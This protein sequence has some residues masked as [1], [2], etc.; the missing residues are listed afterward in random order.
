MAIV[1]MES[2]FTW[3]LQ[4]GAVWWGRRCHEGQHWPRQDI[5][6]GPASQPCDKNLKGWILKMFSPTQM[7]ITC[8]SSMVSSSHEEEQEG[9][10]AW[11]LRNEHLFPQQGHLAIVIVIVYKHWPWIWLS[12]FMCHTQEFPSHDNDGSSFV[13]R[14]PSLWE[15]SSRHRKKRTLPQSIVWNITAENHCNKSLKDDPVQL[16]SK[17]AFQSLRFRKKCNRWNR[18]LTTQVCFCLLLPP[19]NCLTREVWPWLSKK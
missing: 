8:L 10:V 18:F 11:E 2:K 3:W 15:P 16:F 17:P 19:V 14:G 13:T 4:L 7:T 6:P 1:L 12:H 5:P 9:K